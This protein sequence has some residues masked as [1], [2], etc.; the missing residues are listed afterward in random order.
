MKDKTDFIHENS[1]TVDMYSKKAQGS[2]YT[3]YN[4]KANNPVDN[5][6]IR[7]DPKEILDL[8]QELIS[9]IE[10]FLDKNK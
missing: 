7:I 6:S 5:G 4:L 8:L 1:F 10:K 3:G 2:N 9:I